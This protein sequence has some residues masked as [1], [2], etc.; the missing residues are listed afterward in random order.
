VTLIARSLLTCLLS[1]SFGC[2][3]DVHID[4]DA[5]TRNPS[6]KWRKVITKATKSGTGVDYDLIASRPK[7]LAKYLA[8]VGKHGQH[9]D[10]WGESK[11]DRRIAHLANAHNAMLIHQLLEHRP[12]TSPD[13]VQLGLYKWP[14][15]GLSYGVRYRLDGE[16]VHLAKLRAHETVARYQDPLLWLLFH[17]GTVGSPPLKWWPDKGLQGALKKT[18][19]DLLKTEIWLAPTEAGWA[20]HPLFLTHEQDF[21]GWD[22]KESL[23]DWLTPYAPDSAKDWLADHAEDC[24]LTALPEQRRLNQAE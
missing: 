1:L 12:V 5:P 6:K 18:L 7:A 20:I 9:S 11:E 13:D 22:D 4:R 17:D 14:G 15:A 8:W 24:T 19:R 10:W 16:W 2:Q 3:R 21:I 23:C